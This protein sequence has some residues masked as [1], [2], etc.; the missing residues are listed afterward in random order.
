MT[1]YDGTFWVL[2]VLQVATWLFIIHLA[3]RNDTQR[4]LLALLIEK[5]IIT[6]KE[7]DQ[8]RL[9]DLVK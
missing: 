8:I 2:L 9:E 6:Q 3:D 1:Q 5:R 4:K 7:L